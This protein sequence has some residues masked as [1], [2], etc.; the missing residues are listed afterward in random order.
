MRLFSLTLII[1]IL[2]LVGCSGPPGSLKKTAVRATQLLSSELSN[3]NEFSQINEPELIDMHQISESEWCLVYEV[4]DEASFASRWQKEES[5]WVQVELR[6]F[7]TDCN[8]VR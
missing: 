8:W 2:F 6:P 1:S 3:V 5:G 4:T 7:V